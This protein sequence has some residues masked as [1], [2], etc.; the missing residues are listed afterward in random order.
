MSRIPIAFAAGL[1]GFLIYVITIVMIADVVQT[2]HWA[3][4]AGYF[5]V[6][7]SVWVIPIRWLMYW[8]VGQR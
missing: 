5:I 7:G 3:I 6:A 1:L 4:Q 2:Q 8:S